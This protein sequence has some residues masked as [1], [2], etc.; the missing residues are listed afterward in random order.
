[1]NK[2]L[3]RMRIL[4]VALTML[5]M[6]SVAT[7]VVALPALDIAINPDPPIQGQIL[8]VTVTSGGNPVEGVFIQ[9]SPNSGTPY[10]DETNA[11][12]QAVYEPEL[13]GTLKIVA[14]KDGYASKTIETSVGSPP[15][16]TVTSPN[17]GE[18]WKVGS[19]HAITWTAIAGSRPLATNPITI[20]YSTNNGATYTTIATNEPDDESYTWTIPSTTSIACIVKV[21]AEDITGMKGFDVSDASFTISEEEEVVEEEIHHVVGGG[22][23]APKDSDGDGYTDIQEMLAETDPNNPCD[24]DPECAACLAVRPATPTPAPVVTPTPTPAVTPT[25]PPSVPTPTPTPTPTPPPTVIPWFWIIIAIVAAAIIVS[26]IYVL[27]Q[28]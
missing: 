11:T 1:M 28:K 13:T 10:Y 26:V 14:T 20:Q 3:A 12:G 24:P 21:I 23:G 18:D 2:K 19:S 16:V 15:A 17:G 6:C 7:L 8:T 4:S 25:V 22:G 27:R 5:L 9:F